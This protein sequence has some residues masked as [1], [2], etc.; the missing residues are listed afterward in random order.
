MRQRI[1][2][3]EQQD[4]AEINITPMLD[5]VFIMLI[6]FIVSTSFIRE[7]GV[8]VNRP[9]AKSSETQTKTAV[10]IALT[11]DE[12][13]WLDRRAIDIRM[14]RPAMERLKAEQTEVAVVVQADKL[15]TT[16]QL[17]ALLDQLRLAGI[18]YTVAT[19]SE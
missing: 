17:V 18:P 9:V 19:T 7:A 5:V 12:Q 4:E 8:D 16:G 1:H 6:F 3:G 10:M 11:A 15:S 2:F 14:L 13:I